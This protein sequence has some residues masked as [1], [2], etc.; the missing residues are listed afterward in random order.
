MC[1]VAGRTR[2][3]FYHHFPDHAAFV[4]ALLERW[5]ERQTEAVIAAVESA[6]SERLGSLHALASDLD[7]DLDIAVRRFASDDPSAR[8]AVEAVDRQRLD[9]LAGLHAEDHG[10]PPANARRMAELEY[11]LFVGM[12]VLWPDRTPNDLFSYEKLMRA[13]VS[14]V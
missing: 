7:H 10:L 3:S 4:D 6:G 11:A 12:Q 1:E 5:R 13:L 9:F 14:A 8:A 2:G